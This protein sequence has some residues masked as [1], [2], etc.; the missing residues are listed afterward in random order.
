MGSSVNARGFGSSG[1]VSCPKEKSVVRVSIIV[2]MYFVILKGLLVIGYS[3]LVI[4][5]WL[6]VIR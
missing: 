1:R 4:C 6:L 2:V 3:L 5:Y